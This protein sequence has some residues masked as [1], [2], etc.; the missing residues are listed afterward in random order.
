M[1]VLVVTRHLTL[2][3]LLQAVEAEVEVELLL[4]LLVVAEVEAVVLLLVQSE[5]Q[6]SE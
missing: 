5:Q 3:K 6:L 4:V 2:L 1:V